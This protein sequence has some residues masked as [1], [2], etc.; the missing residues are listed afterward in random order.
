MHL[1]DSP[2][3]PRLTAEE[4]ALV[5][6]YL[7]HLYENEIKKEIS[8]LRLSRNSVRY[9]GLRDNLREAFVAD[10]I[11]ALAQW[12]W[13]AFPHGEEFG[14]VHASTIS[15][16]VRIGTKRVAEDRKRLAKLNSA[17]RSVLLDKM[18]TTLEQLLASEEP[19]GD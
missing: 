12:G 10:W 19:D 6:A 2:R 15:G 3:F 17:D 16:W 7:I 18:R 4:T 5:T 8:R 11:D 9:L 1:T 14:L 13:I